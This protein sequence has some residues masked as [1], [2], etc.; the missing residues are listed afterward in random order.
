MI[1]TV[2]YKFSSPIFNVYWGKD[3]PK[4]PPKM[5]STLS[6]GVRASLFS[7]YF[8]SHIW[9]PPLESQIKSVNGHRYRPEFLSLLDHH[10]KAIKDLSLS[11]CSLQSNEAVLFL[12]AT[13]RRD[14]EDHHQLINNLYFSAPWVEILAVAADDDDDA[15]EEYLPCGHLIFIYNVI[16]SNFVL[17]PLYHLTY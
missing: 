4:P 12:V 11:R 6:D 13:Y 15:D 7:V 16:I 8:F 14:K 10:F 2:K 3:L 5:Q 17:L 9:A 1:K